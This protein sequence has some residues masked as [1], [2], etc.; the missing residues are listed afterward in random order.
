MTGAFG[1]FLRWELNEVVRDPYLG[2]WLGGMVLV[3]YVLAYV[4][5]ILGGTTGHALAALLAIGPIGFMFIS[6]GRDGPVREASWQRLVSTYPAT[7][8]HALYG[9]LAGMLGHTVVYLLLVTPGLAWYGLMLPGSRPLILWGLLGYPFLAGGMV[10]IGL[11]LSQLDVRRPMRWA[12]ALAVFFFLA[13]WLTLVSVSDNL[14]LHALLTLSPPVSL[15]HV[16]DAFPPLESSRPIALGVLVWACSF[17]LLVATRRFWKRSVVMPLLGAL[18]LLGAGFAA[19]FGTTVEADPRFNVYESGGDFGIRVM[20][21]DG[22]QPTGGL[23]SPLPVAEPI[24]VTIRIQANMEADSVA[25]LRLDGE[26][27]RVQDDRHTLTAHP[28][29]GDGRQAAPTYEIETVLELRPDR[30]V[31]KDIYRLYGEITTD[32]HRLQAWAIVVGEYPEFKGGLGAAAVASFVPVGV[33]AWRR[34]KLR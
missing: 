10:A 1:H 13:L 21:A 19:S 7:A 20:E 23:T 27:L 26:N 14:I 11:A 32:E 4:L 24:E 8:A 28:D 34:R 5:G 29:G 15:A 30:E 2:A 33:A 18:V 17:S 9:K 25:M 3:A 6:L 22:S 16:L 31:S 12:G